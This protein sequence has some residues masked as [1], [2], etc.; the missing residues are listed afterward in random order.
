MQKFSPS[1]HIERAKR[2]L[3]SL[4]GL[5]VGDSF[6]ECFFTE[7]EL[8]HIASPGPLKDI[9]NRTIPTAHLKPPRKYTGLSNKVSF[10]LFR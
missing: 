10:T 9:A 4:T 2:A 1:K 5:S 6:G 8:G 3:L 7:S